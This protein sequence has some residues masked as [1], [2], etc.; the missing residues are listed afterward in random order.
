MGWTACTFVR[1]SGILA[2][3]L[4][5]AAPSLVLG[6][7]PAQ[8]VQA[9]VECHEDL[10]KAF[11]RNPHFILD[12]KGWAQKRG[13]AYSCEACHGDAARHLAEQGGRGNIWA[14]QPKEAFGAKTQRCLTCHGGRHPQFAA[15]P[16]AKARLDCTACHS[17]H[18]AKESEGLLRTSSTST[19]LCGSCHEDIL[20]KFQMPQRHRLQ[21]G[22]LNCVT[23]HDPH[24][25]E[26]RERLGG[27]KQMACLRCHTD[28]QGPF[29]FEHGSVLVEGCTTC[30]DP[31]GSPNRRQLIFQRT[32]DLCYSCHTAVPAF[33]R[34]FRPDTQCTNCH[35]SIHGSNLSP[36]FLK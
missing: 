11:Q 34:R 36:F 10:V 28:K 15:S 1:G 13:A 5:G 9:C 35:S 8:S 26:P 18:A 16:H 7:A 14:F 31:H 22:I 20:A 23:C 24:A 6:Q 33:H 32:A 27:V 3:S 25:P 17:V 2:L 30:H 29:V 21:E 19:D 12:T 4:L